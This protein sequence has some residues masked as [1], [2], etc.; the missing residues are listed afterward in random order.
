MFLQHDPVYTIGNSGDTENL[1]VPIEETGAEFYKTNRGGDITYHGPGQLTVYPIFDLDSFG[2]GVREYVNLLEEVIIDCLEIY[3]IKGGR[4]KEASG[5]WIDIDSAAPR[6]ICAI[7][8]KVSRG[9]TM[10]G[11]AFNVNTDLSYFDNIVPC[12]LEDKGVTSLQA[13]LGKE[14]DFY[15]VCETLLGCFEKRF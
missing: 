11:L 9:I 13:E 3:G 14:L 10:H 5:V 1:K 6:K 7:G 2:I 4:I 8:I 15:E 12:G